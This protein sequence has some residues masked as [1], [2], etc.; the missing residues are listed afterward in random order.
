MLPEW[1]KMTLRDD[2]D[3]IPLIRVD[4]DKAYPAVLKELADMGEVNMGTEEQPIMV[5]CDPSNPDQYWLEVAYQCIKMTLQKVAG[6]KIEIHFKDATKKWAQKNFAEGRGWFKAT[7]G[8]EARK[9]FQK[10]YGSL[11]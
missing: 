10:V 6:M 8:L 3:K 11:P 1:A 7:K 9:H 4:T 2:M 5:E